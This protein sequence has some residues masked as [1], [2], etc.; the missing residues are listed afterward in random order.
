MAT[1]SVDELVFNRRDELPAA[2]I[3]ALNSNFESEAI[4]IL[5]AGSAAPLPRVSQTDLSN[6]FNT[7]FA[8][9][10][11]ATTDQSWNGPYMSNR[12]QHWLKVIDR[13]P[14]RLPKLSEIV[15]LVRLDWVAA[16]EDYRLNAQVEAL[17]N[18]YSIVLLNDSK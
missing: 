12:G 15:D 3:Q 7:A 5:E 9:Q 13:N 10:V 18:Q 2:T 11:F 14:Q 8:A 6:I 17:V 16:E 1:V 4:L